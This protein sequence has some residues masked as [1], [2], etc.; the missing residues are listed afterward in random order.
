MEGKILLGRDK[1]IHEVPET[2]WKQHLTQAPQSGQKRLAFMTDAHHQVRYF[3]VRE[4]VNTQK[5]IKPEFISDALK[6]PNEQVNAIL[7]EL[8]RKLF[9]L[10]RNEQN[11]VIW[12]YPVTVESTPHRLVFNS[13]ERLYGA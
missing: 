5:P 10:V 6:M 3:V 12:A 8:E 1:D 7:E 4:L 11:E 2:M 13:G 9:F